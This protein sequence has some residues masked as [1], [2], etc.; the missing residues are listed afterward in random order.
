MNAPVY[1]L[2]GLRT[3]SGMDFGGINATLRCNDKPVAFIIDDGNG[4]SMEIDFRNPGQ[5][6]ASCK[7][8]ANTWRDAEAAAMA[9]AL[10]WFNTSPEAAECRAFDEE[11]NQKYPDTKRAKT[12]RDALESWINTTVDAMQ[13]KKRLDRA[14]KTKTLF[15]LP[16][17]KPGE[18]RTLKI[19]YSDPRAAAYLSAKYPKA[20]VYGVSA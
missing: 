1:T 9:W 20:T 17:D 13:E 6:P 10:D 19:P 4:G 18:W 7:A 14:A 2:S 12:G 16:D 8:A 3:F 5:S 11:L 15:R